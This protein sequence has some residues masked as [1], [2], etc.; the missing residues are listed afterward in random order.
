ML[1]SPAGPADLDEVE[2]YTTRGHGFY[3]FG[4]EQRGFSELLVGVV[5]TGFLPRWADFLGHDVR[6]YPKEKAKSDD[7]VPKLPANTFCTLR[8]LL[9]AIPEISDLFAEVFESEPSWIMP[10]PDIEV[11]TNH[12][13]SNGRRSKALTSNLSTARVRSHRQGLKTLDGQSP[14]FRG[15]PMLRTARYSAP[16]SIIRIVIIGSTPCRVIKAHSKTAAR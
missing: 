11:Q 1:A 5:A 14:S 16:G 6:G 13:R 8:E 2:G 3:A 12:R 10:V 4:T 9:S 15:Y 7:A